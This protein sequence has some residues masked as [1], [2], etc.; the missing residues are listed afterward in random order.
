MTHTHDIFSTELKKEK[1][2][3]DGPMTNYP[4]NS[5][6]VISADN[7]DFMHI[8]GRV[9]SGKKQSSWHGTTIQ[10]VQ[11]QPHYLTDNTAKLGKAT[12]HNHTLF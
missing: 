9:Y 2:M 8:F 3:E 1:R 7:L 5:F 4:Q 12:F 6:L 10:V 11:P